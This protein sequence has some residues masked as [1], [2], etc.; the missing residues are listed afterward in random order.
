[1]SRPVLLLDMD[2]P[3]ADFDAACFHLIETNGWE[4]DFDHLDDPRRERFMTANMPNR[5]EAMMLRHTIDTDPDWFENLPVTVG[6]TEERVAEL[7]GNFDV[8][9]CTKP[10]E[11]NPT[12]RDD[13]GRWL[14][15]Y[16]PDLEHKLIIA[17]DKSRVS[18]D[19]LLDDAPKLEWIDRADWVP[20]I[21]PEP[22]NQR[23]GRL[24]QLPTWTWGDPV[25]SLFEVL[26]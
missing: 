1:M 13:K 11:K 22:Y 25:E 21:F 3:L 10:L 17:P 20:V 7:M 18:G 15:R 6:A 2:G 4:V 16:F 9:V 26:R 8:W 14:R 12:C 24:A 19:I 5:R 23:G